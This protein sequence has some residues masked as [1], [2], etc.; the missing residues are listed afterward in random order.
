MKSTR[1]PVLSVNWS[2]TPRS[3]ESSR[4]VAGPQP[5][6]VMTG[7]LA[8]GSPDARLQPTE[9]RQTA[10]RNSGSH[11]LAR[12]LTF[13]AMDSLRCTSLGPTFYSSEDV[14]PD[15]LATGS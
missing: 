2:N 5:M 3:M 15:G 7:G 10:S 14:G 4:W 6:N 12:A 9:D 13:T 11:G 1:I 8:G